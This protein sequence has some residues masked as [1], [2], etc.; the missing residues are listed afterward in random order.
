MCL[1]L[2]RMTTIKNLILK[3]ILRLPASEVAKS[4]IVEGPQY[5]IYQKRD[6][7]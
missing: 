5:S 2:G 4:H 7:I 3:I 1:N 6:E